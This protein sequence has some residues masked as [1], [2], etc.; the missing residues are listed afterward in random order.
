MMI[1]TIRRTVPSPMYMRLPPF[2]VDCFSP[3]GL[4]HKPRHT[5]RKE[6]RN[7]DRS[8]SRGREPT[9]LPASDIRGSYSGGPVGG[10]CP[11][12]RRPQ[13]GP[14]GRPDGLG[15]TAYCASA[16]SLRDSATEPGVPLL[17]DRR[18][19]PPRAHAPEVDLVELLGLP[20]ARP[21]AQG[22]RLLE[23]G[24]VSLTTTRTR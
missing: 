16:V 20:Q 2:V 7:E 9:I 22:V 15:R 6:G 8:P 24:H 3:V 13:A 18:A 5:V 21:L 11:A 14:T 17:R 4:T 19:D 10:A 1:R 12:R 23:M